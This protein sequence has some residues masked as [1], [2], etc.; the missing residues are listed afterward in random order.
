MDEILYAEIVDIDEILE[1]SVDINGILK[2][3]TGERGE[4]GERGFGCYVGT[5][6]PPEGENILVW[7]DSSDV[8]TSEFATKKDIESARQE[9]VDDISVV[10]EGYAKLTDIPDLSGYVTDEEAKEF[11][12]KSDIPEPIDT[13]GF[14]LKTE[15]P[16]T[17]GFALKTEIPDTS[18]FQTESQVN[19]LINNALGVIE[20][21][22]Y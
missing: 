21:G 4:R 17:S 22:S 18:S 14:A 11:A 1:G 8:S 20:N 12:L 10:L 15:I 13:S 19:T 5:D 2:G 6:E 7:F 9:V 3:D 16:D